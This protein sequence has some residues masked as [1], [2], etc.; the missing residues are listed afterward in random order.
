MHVLRPRSI[1]A[2]PP[3]TSIPGA[4]VTRTTNRALHAVLTYPCAARDNPQTPAAERHGEGRI[5][6]PR[7]LATQLQMP[8]IP[9]HPAVLEPRLPYASRRSTTH[10]LR[11]Q[12]PAACQLQLHRLRRAPNVRRAAGVVPPRAVAV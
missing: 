12:H 11:L 9:R 5:H 2:T 1:L 10:Y 4:Q 7:I 3:H 6:P 8:R